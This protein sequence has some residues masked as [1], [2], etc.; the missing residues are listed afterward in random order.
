METF[1]VCAGMMKS[2]IGEVAVECSPGIVECGYRLDDTTSFC[3]SLESW[4]WTTQVIAAMAECTASCALTR[5][6]QE[7]LG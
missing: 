6:D 5:V 2:A 1:Y 4:T 3:S 7:C